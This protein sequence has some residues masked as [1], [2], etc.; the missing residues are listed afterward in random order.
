M[1]EESS[2]FKMKGSPMHAGTDAHRSALKQWWNPFN[3]EVKSSRIDSKSYTPG[4]DGDAGTSTETKSKTYQNWLTGNR[5]VVTKKTDK[6]GGPG[7]VAGSETKTRKTTTKLKKYGKKKQKSGYDDGVTYDTREYKFDKQKSKTKTKI[8]GA[9]WG[10]GKKG[11]GSWSDK[12]STTDYTKAE[13]I[14][15]TEGVYPEDKD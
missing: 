9:V 11:K 1:S 2:G 13:P 4:D 15:G 6:S 8:K 7:E 14:Y 5:K 12:T 10:K 3:R